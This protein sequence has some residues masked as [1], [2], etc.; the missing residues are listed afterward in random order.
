MG[1][2]HLMTRKGYDVEKLINLLKTFKEKHKVEVIL[3]PGSAVAWQIGVLIGRVLDMVN[4]RGIETLL[5]DVSFTA[6]M[7]DTLEMPYRPTI[8]GASSI[9]IEGKPTYRI[10]GSSCLAGDYLMEYSFEEPV[11]IGD[12]IVFEDMMHYTTVKST[13]F[14]GVYHPIMAI[15]EEDDSLNIVREFG[16]EDY[17]NRMG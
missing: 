6:H 3:E 7:P 15:W 9:I 10:G 5:L 14:N 8:V 2:G 11:K 4:S 17:K 12:R 13:M 1:G 16:Y